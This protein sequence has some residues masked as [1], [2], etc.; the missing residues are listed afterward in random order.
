MRKTSTLLIFLVL[1][2]GIALA[3]TAKFYS[4]EVSFNLTSENTTVEIDFT[5][6]LSNVTAKSDRIE[7]AGGDFIVN[8]TGNQLDINISTFDPTA[9]EGSTAVEFEANTTDGNNVEFNITG[10]KAGSDYAVLRDSSDFASQT[11]DNGFVNFSSDSWSPHTFKVTEDETAPSLSLSLGKSSIDTG[12]SIE[13]TCSAS[14]SG[15]GVS[16]TTLEVEDPDGD[17]SSH[18]CGSDF[19]DTSVSGT[20]TVTYSAT[21]NAGNSGSTSKDFDASSS[22]GSSSSSSSVSSTPSLSKSWSIGEYTDFEVEDDGDEV[23]GFR[24]VPKSSEAR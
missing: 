15:S 2:S 3:G 20:Y 18:T 5:G 19:S 1:V 16:S 17:T 11:A 22:S 7:T 4:N 10:L 21:D 24:D 12:S 23:E 6:N 9:A 14:D 8:N 13:I